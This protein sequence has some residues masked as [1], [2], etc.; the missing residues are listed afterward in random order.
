MIETAQEFVD[1]LLNY[2]PKSDDISPELTDGLKAY[3]RRNNFNDV[4]LD[5][6]YAIIQENCGNFPTVRVVAKLW[7]EHGERFEKGITPDNSAISKFKHSGWREVIQ[8][9]QGIRAAQ[10]Y[11]IL[12]NSEIDILTDYDDLNYVYKLL[13]AVSVLVMPEDRK[14]VYMRKVKED[15]DNNIPIKLDRVRASIQRRLDE[16]EEKYGLQEQEVTDKLTK[17]VSDMQSSFGSRSK[18]LELSDYEKEQCRLG[19]R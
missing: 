16:Y 9:V 10:E 4:E 12:K 6:L 1:K 5:K 8:E 18:Q 11:R 13:Q 19:F 15:I 17:S 3:I 2:F 14:D 7:K